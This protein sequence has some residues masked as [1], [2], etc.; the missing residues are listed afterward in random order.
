MDDRATAEKPPAGT[1]GRSP[2]ELHATLAAL[3]RAYRENA[4][5]D[6]FG[7][8]IA[9]M[10]LEL[11]RQVDRDEI[12][13]GDLEGVVQHLSARALLR[14][15]GR[16]AAYVGERD[17]AAN[18]ARLARLFDKVAQPAEGRTVPFERF[19][20]V[21]EAWH[22]GIVFT[23]HPTFATPLPLS[24]RIAGLAAAGVPE[25]PPADLAEAR[26]R[27][28]KVTLDD[29]FRWAM[30]AIANA[31]DALDRLYR[32][33]LEVARRH[34]PESWHTLKPRLVSVAS[35][36]GY[37]LDGRSD[38]GWTDTLGMRL[39]VKHAQL[40][41]V[42][43]ACQALRA[44]ADAEAAAPTL[45][46]AESILALAAKQV[47]LQIEAAF[48]AGNPAERAPPLARRLVEGREQAL[49]GSARLEQLLDRAVEQAATPALATELAALRAGL[50]GHGLG[51]AH[52]HVRLNA[53]QL[54]NAI[55]RQ[56]GIEGS[57]A[58]P[59]HRRSFVAAVNEL[60]AG[61]RPATVNLGSLLAER[62][63]A[64]RLFMLIAE[65]AK[66]IDGDSPVRFLI[67]ETETAYTLLVALYF[68]RLF[69]VER[70]IE[71]SP[72]FET[73]DALDRGDGVLDEALRSPHFRQHIERR[74][75]LCVQFG[76]SDSGRYIGQMAATF[77]IERLRLRIADMLARHKL[78]GIQVVLFNTHGESI[79]R[80]GHP[81]SM[82]DRFAY[83]A[84]PASRRAL[85][86]AGA[87]V[88]E[89]SSFQG[90]DGYLPF[91]APELAF[92]ALTRIVE[93]MLEAGPEAADDPIYAEADFASEFFT[94]VRQDFARLVE[95]PDYAAL[96]GA[97]GTA[98]L[99]SAGSR[100]TRR[101][102]DSWSGPKELLH[103]SQIRAI[104]NN[105]LLQNFGL[106][107]NTVYG[108]GRATA[109][110]PERF[111]ELRR[112]SPRF[113][114]ALAMV[115]MAHG[116]GDLD[117]LRAYV[118]LLDPGVWLNRSARTRRPGRREE[119]RRIARHL[120]RSDLHPR[121]MRV[122]RKLQGDHLLLRDELASV[123]GDGP[124]PAFPA[125]ETKAELALLQA[126]RIALLHRIYLLATH[127]PDFTP[128]M[129]LSR[130]DLIQRILHLDV[131]EAVR[132][133]KE[134][135]PRRDGGEADGADYAEPASYAGT[136][137]RTYEAEHKE[138]FE[139]MAASFELTRRI[140][141]ALA[142]HMGAIG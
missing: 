14:R 98:L 37:D 43:D 138:L 30:A 82:A 100:P 128:H 15:A 121:L 36:V 42:R 63:S 120:E 97:F 129:E 130:D 134:I 142:Y 20:A 125:E 77:W 135:F 113:R 76:F 22:Y 27:P 5:Q 25:E 2:A 8:P 11:T 55:R 101:Q 112:T 70:L 57:P 96:L 18:E 41:R 109:K 104:P 35:W 119:L 38:I 31:R 114:R 49:V 52:T 62:A 66:H 40:L 53:T 51:L 10:A 29:E 131:E 110:D 54:H 48:G 99:D 80:G 33:V 85:Q 12:G 9:R 44:R 68:A 7:N 87:T 60:L 6:P 84:P 16:L 83:L 86:H 26:H 23:A 127:I 50:A 72:L 19:R 34:Y 139:P 45:E 115:E 24:R 133:L 74:G 17:V 124:P 92:A 111:R 32:V 46:L 123:G 69:D 71:I 65:M 39:R 90:G 56:I 108:L 141:A 73:A 116:L 21:V 103:P 117:V 59:G 102:H 75:R 106:L 61:V 95:D 105:A 67:A 93:G 89:E 136:A 91:L 58:D 28:P 64:R 4:E 118:D 78:A 81:I 13:H 3:L 1:A 137:E 140:G 132:L 122:Y 88:K 94:V 47:E 107:A 126:L 79:G